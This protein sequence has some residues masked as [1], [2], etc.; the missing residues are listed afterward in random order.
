MRTHVTATDE[1]AIMV[2]QHS[3]NHAFLYQTNTRNKCESL[4]DR[5]DLDLRGVCGKNMDLKLSV[6]VLNVIVDLINKFEPLDQ[7]RRNFN[8]QVNRILTSAKLSRRA[9]GAESEDS[10][11]GDLLIVSGAD[12]SARLGR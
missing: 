6:P 1:M 7:V 10:Q 3:C 4:N 8:C 11:A 5:N 12:G 2:V 9:G